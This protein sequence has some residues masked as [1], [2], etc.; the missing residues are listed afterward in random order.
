M[1]DVFTRDADALHRALDRGGDEVQVNVSRATAEWLV[2]LVEARARGQEVVTTR[3]RAK[4]A[5]AEAAE[6]LGM[7]QTPGAQ[8]DG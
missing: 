3:G 7:S 6:V 8:A 1:T 4:V 5:P 2:E